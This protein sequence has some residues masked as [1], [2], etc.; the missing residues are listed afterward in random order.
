MSRTRRLAVLDNFEHVLPAAEL[1]PQHLL[2]N[3]EVKVLVTSRACRPP[4]YDTDTAGLLLP[5]GG[6]VPL[7]VDE[8]AAEGA[9]GP[10]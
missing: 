10:A 8:Q 6:L 7:A 9:E 3:S 4:A 1:I 5:S 2:A